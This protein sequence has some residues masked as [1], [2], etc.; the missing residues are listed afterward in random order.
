MQFSVRIRVG[1][2][3]AVAALVVEEL[4]R[5]IPRPSGPRTVA[6]VAVPD[7]VDAVAVAVDGSVRTLLFALLF[8]VTAFLVLGVKEHQSL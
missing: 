8:S 5:Q 4:L 6:E 7:L 1:L 2:P 3:S